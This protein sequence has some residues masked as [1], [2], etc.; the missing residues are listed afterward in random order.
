MS[1]TYNSINSFRKAIS[2]ICRK[3]KH[4]YTSCQKDIC[5]RLLGLSFEDIWEL[6]YLLRELGTA[7]IIKLR[8]LN[9]Q[10][11]LSHADGFRLIIC[12]NRNKSSVTFLGVYPKRGPLQKLDQLKQEYAT[13]LKEY[14]DELSKSILICHDIEKHLAEIE[15]NP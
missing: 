15:C 14:G 6:P 9:S 4:G 12:C 8:L 2:H 3:E 7:R 11:K 1:V 5:D 13:Q 10:Q